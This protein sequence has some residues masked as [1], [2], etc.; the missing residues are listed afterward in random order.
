MILMH[1]QEQEEGFDPKRCVCREGKTNCEFADWHQIRVYYPFET[2]S[3][4]E[5]EDYY[6]LHHLLLPASAS[7]SALP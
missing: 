2:F 6:P 5:Q 3:L 7:A 4:Y 1:I